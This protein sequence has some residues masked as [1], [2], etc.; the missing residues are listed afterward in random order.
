M[1]DLPKPRR[2]VEVRME[3]SG[4]SWE[5]INRALHSIRTDLIAEG[6]LR[7]MV[8]GGCGSGW[9]IS[10]SE[11][12]TITHESWRESLDAYLA[13]LDREKTP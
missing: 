10:V 13:A 9:W 11:N 4:D 12:E 1:T 2:R 8:S 3:I 7:N 5:E 6:S